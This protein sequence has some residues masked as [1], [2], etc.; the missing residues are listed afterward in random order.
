MEIYDTIRRH[1]PWTIRHLTRRIKREANW[2]RNARRSVAS[3]F[4]DV[5]SGRQWGQAD[6]DFHSGP[7][8]TGLSASQYADCIRDYIRRLG[9]RSVVDIGCGDFR[10]ASGFVTGDVDYTGVDV[11][12][13][14][15]ARN[16]A[17]FASGT[18]RFVNLDATRDELPDGELCLIREVLQH[19]SNSQIASVLHATRKFRHVIYSDY[20]PAPGARFWPNRDITHGRDTRIWRDSAVLLDQPPFNRKMEL[21]LEVA[22]HDILRQPG[23]C[24]RT[25]RLTDQGA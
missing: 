21:L 4:Q 11:V 3:V 12:A 25:Y 19:L 13:S 15:V 23:E 22:S 1:T 10:V 14:L 6:D 24:I 16:Q 7:G 20:Q 2:V 8:S 5:Y 9:I 17:A 18:V